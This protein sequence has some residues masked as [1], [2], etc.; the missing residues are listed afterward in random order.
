M[1]LLILCHSLRTTTSSHANIPLLRIGLTMDAATVIGT[2]ASVI[3]IGG[4]FL[5][6]ARW[7]LKKQTE[8]LVKEYLADIKESSSQLLPNHGSSLNDVVQLQVL[9]ILKKLDRGQDEIRDE[10]TEIK[11]NVAR[12]EGRFDQYVEENKE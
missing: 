8:D 12:L 4:V 2:S 10:Q 6:F 1:K 7:I 9:P 3:G 11:V 5:G